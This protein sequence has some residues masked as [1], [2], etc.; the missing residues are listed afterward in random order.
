V[1]LVLIKGSISTTHR[2]ICFW[3]G[4]FFILHE[5]LKLT[6]LILVNERGKMSISFS[7]VDG[8]FLKLGFRR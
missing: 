7:F 6:A 2:V 4:K 1:A 8:G 3:T 5:I